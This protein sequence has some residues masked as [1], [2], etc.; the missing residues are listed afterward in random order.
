VASTTTAATIQAVK[1]RRG[2][3][4]VGVVPGASGSLNVLAQVSAAFGE[5]NAS[6]A[7]PIARTE[8][9]RAAGSQLAARSMMRSKPS[10]KS[11]RSSP[12]G[13]RLPVPMSLKIFVTSSPGN[14]GRPVTHS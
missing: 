8:G 3:D 5:A 6:S 7:F 10:G 9:N 1:E 12:A 2:V 11:R 14:A 13:G 4:S